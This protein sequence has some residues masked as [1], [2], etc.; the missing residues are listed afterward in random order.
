MSIDI[1]AKALSSLQAE[2]SVSKIPA[3]AYTLGYQRGWDD[4]LALAI[5]VEQAI[6]NDDNGLFSD[7]MPA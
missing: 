5:Q 2:G 4:A 6:N 7:R 1:I 3:E